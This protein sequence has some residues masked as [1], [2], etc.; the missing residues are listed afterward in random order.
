M[1]TAGWSGPGEPGYTAATAVFNLAHPAEPAAAVTVR[2][3]GEIRAALAAAAERDLRVHVL[4]TGHGSANARS[5]AGALLVRTEPDGPVEVDSAAGIAR[6]PAGTRWGAVVD[7][8]MPHGL[9]APHGS[10]PLVGVV[11]YLLRGGVSFYGRYTGLASNRVRAIELVT[12]DGEHRRTDATTD[13]E[14]FRALRGGGGGFGIVTAVEVELFEAPSVVTG[15]A[16]WPAAHAERLLATWLAWSRTAPREVT[17]SLRL[18][19]LPPLPEIPEPLRAGTVLC[20]D[21]VALGHTADPATALGQADDLLGPLREIAEPLLDTWH[22][23]KPADVVQTHMDPTEP[24]P[25]FGDH[26][27]FGDLGEAAAERFLG[28]LRKDTTLTNAELRQLGGALAEPSPAGGVLDH[29]PAGFAYMGG[30]VPFGV[31]PEAIVAR[32]AEIREALSPWALPGTAPSFVENLEQP[33][34][35]L[36]AAQ[37]AEVTRVR[38]RVDPHGRFAGDVSPNA[39]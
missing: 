33:Q 5:M 6:I 18:M 30:G 17:T 36:S 20:V 7:A 10:S 13:P 2:T 34:G 19:N 1:T 39:S 21:G 23:A 4:G 25:I 16:Y 24:F 12:A 32:C 22:P 26:L 27:L 9:A 37:V 15:A 31:T 35:H 14:L 29:L 8:A 11:G 38:A 28:L 3:A